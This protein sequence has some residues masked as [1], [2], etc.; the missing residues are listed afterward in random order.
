QNY[1]LIANGMAPIP[2]MQS[3]VQLVGYDGSIFP[4]W[5]VLSHFFDPTVTVNVNEWPPSIVGPDKS[6]YFGVF[7]SPY[8]PFQYSSLSQT[9]SGMNPTPYSP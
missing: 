7:P 3:T 6:I 4:N 2:Q 8:P 9:V 5:P 1:S